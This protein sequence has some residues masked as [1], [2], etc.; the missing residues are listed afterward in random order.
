MGAYLEFDV[1]KDESRHQAVADFMKT[2]GPAHCVLTSGMGAATHCH[3]IDEMRHMMVSLRM[4]GLSE[5]DVDLM[6]KDTPAQLL[7]LD[8]ESKPWRGY[9]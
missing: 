1:P 2:V 9:I 5:K 4:N 6:T 3:P 8:E 7:S